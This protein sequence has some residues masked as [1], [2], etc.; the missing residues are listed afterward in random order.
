MIFLPLEFHTN[1]KLWGEDANDFNPERFSS[2]SFK[3]IH[4][5][6][7]FPFSKGPRVCPGSKYAWVSMKAFLS[8]FLM[9]YKVSSSLKY[10]DLKFQLKLAIN[11]QQGF[12]IKIEKR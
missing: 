3:K 1:Q 5:Y 12:M 8:K 2:E 10:D 11:V 4:P 6:A 7:Y 9:K